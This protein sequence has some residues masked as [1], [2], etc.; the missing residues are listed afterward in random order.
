M[1]FQPQKNRFTHMRTSKHP[2]SVVCLGVQFRV[3]GG[4]E[5]FLVRLKS[6][7]LYTDCE[8][9]LKPRPCKEKGRISDQ[10][11]VLYFICL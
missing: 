11:K 1:G 3:G 7:Y 5:Q 2:G 10:S 6:P 9:L 4:G 8:W